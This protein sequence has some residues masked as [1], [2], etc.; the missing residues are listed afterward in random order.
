MRD[1]LR[2]LTGRS[3]KDKQDNRYCSSYESRILEL[4]DYAVTAMQDAI[5]L[6]P[7]TVPS[8]PVHCDESPLLKVTRMATKV[9]CALNK[10]LD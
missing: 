9:P 4:T 3:K 8:R 7:L 6:T 5:H 1:R 2:Q 10:S